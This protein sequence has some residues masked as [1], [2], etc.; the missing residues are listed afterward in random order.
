MK[1]ARELTLLHGLID[2]VDL[3]RIHW[4]VLEED[5]SAALS[6]VQNKT[7][8]TIRS[9]V[10]DRLFELGDLSGKRDTRFVGWD[11]PLDE[12]IKRIHDIYVTHFDDRGLWTVFCWLN[13]TDKGEQIARA[14]EEK[15]EDS[16]G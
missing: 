13:L 2:W 3:G 8:E 15:H 5:P 6:D 4:H 16:L 9:L 10:S 1:T 14:L 12:S 7:L 11:T